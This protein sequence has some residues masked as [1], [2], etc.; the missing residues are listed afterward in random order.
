ME[1]LQQ[2]IFHKTNT[3]VYNFHETEITYVVFEVLTAAVTKSTIFWDITP[4]SP[5]RV[6][7]H[8]RGTYRLHLQRRKISRARNHRES[9]WQTKFCFLARLIFRPWRWRR[10]APLKRWLTFNGLHGIVSQK[11]VFF[12]ITYFWSILRLYCNMYAME[13]PLLGNVQAI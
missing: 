12:K 11:M 4:C 7:W 5:L 3:N 1:E 2:Y 10:Y 6:N 9:R 13:W 8:F